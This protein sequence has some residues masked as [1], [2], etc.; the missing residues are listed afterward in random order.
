MLSY[1]INNLLYESITRSMTFLFPHAI[2]KMRIG[3]DTESHLLQLP[4]DISIIIFSN[5]NIIDIVRLELVNMSFKNLIRKNNWTNINIG[6]SLNFCDDYYNNVLYYLHEKNCIVQNLDVV[7]TILSTHKLMVENLSISYFNEEILKI[8]HH[9]RRIKLRGWGITNQSLG[10]IKNAKNISISDY[11]YMLLI[12]IPIHQK[13]D[14][15]LTDDTDAINDTGLSNLVN[16]HKVKLYHCTDIT[17]TGLGYLANCDTVKLS[18]C[19]VTD[20]GLKNL[21]KCRKVDLHYCDEITN[22]GLNYLVN[23]C[24]KIVITHC[25][26]ITRHNVDHQ[27]ENNSSILIIDYILIPI[28]KK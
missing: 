10:Y 8:I 4:A 7:K 15:L 14:A 3:D 5:L 1:Q 17:E 21:V 2:T 24:E 11:P 23:N 22:V 28:V 16:C 25:T 18:H 12:I 13:K 6:L 20:N 19:K 26:N 27:I 9:C